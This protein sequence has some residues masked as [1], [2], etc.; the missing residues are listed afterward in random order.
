M[1]FWVWQEISSESSE[2][3]RKA[4]VPAR[5]HLLLDWPY[6]NSKNKG[7]KMVPCGKYHLELRI[8][9]C[10]P[11][12]GLF[13]FQHRWDPQHFPFPIQMT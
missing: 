12:N 11:G 2:R 5:G 4:G 8:R 1:L 3:V 6:Y 10:V 9:R 13:T 7:H